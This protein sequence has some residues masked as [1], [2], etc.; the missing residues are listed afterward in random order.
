MKKRILLLIY[1]WLFKSKYTLYN[2]HAE[3]ENA[4]LYASRTK[5]SYK[6][7][8]HTIF[9]VLGLILVL[10]FS[11]MLF[12]CAP[13]QPQ[14]IYK[15]VSVPVKCNITI[16]DKPRYTGNVVIDNINILKYSDTLL[17]NLNK[18]K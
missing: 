15:Y 18:C 2:N 8:V 9:R 1:T 5:Y 4:K 10:F 6:W 11:F 17:L 7:W 16:P 3:Y 12:G 14:V 13:K